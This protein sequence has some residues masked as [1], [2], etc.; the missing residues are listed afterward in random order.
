[1]TLPGVMSRQTPVSI[2]AVASLSI[3]VPSAQVPRAMQRGFDAE[4]VLTPVA[5]RLGIGVDRLKAQLQQGTSLAT[6]ATAKG[7]TRD[8]LLEVVKNGLAKTEAARAQFGLPSAANRRTLAIDKAANAIADGDVLPLPTVASA[9]DL[10]AA[11]K[12]ASGMFG[13]RRPANK[14]VKNDQAALAHTSTLL[15]LAPDEVSQRLRGGTSLRQLATDQDVDF[16][17]LMDVIRAGML[18]DAVA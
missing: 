6:I 11:G 18:Y 12:D 5:E 9:A 14:Q 13:Q 8:D 4:Q 7:I 2:T 17:A 10:A 1:M 3:P 16:R 15:K